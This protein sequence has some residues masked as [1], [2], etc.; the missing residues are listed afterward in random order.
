MQ[1]L[2]NSIR[3]KVALSIVFVSIGALVA[4]EAFT[5]AYNVILDEP[6]LAR[7][8]FTFQKPLIFGL[9][10]VFIL[11]V[12]LAL[13]RSLAPLYRYV[14]DPASADEALYARARRAALGVPKAIL[15]INLT[16]WIAGT[17]V[18]F[19]LNGWKAPGGTPLG[20]V[21]AFKITEG[22]LFSTLNSLIINRLLIEPKTLL[23]IERVRTGEHDYFAEY[24]E[25][26]TTLLAAATSVVHLAY[27]ARY[28]ILKAPGSRGPGNLPLSFAIVGG[29]V[30]LTATAIINL[31]QRDNSSQ[32]RTLRERLIGLAESGSVDLSAKATI[33]N[34]DDI[35]SVADAFNAYAESL[36]RMIG[37]IGS[38]TAVLERSCDDLAAGVKTVQ[39][40]LDG[41]KD[42]VRKIGRHVEEETAEIERSDGVI[43]SMGEAI[44]RQRD[45]LDAQAV[46]VTESSAGIEQMI[47]SLRSVAGNVAQI[48]STYDGLTKATEEGKRRVAETD[49]TIVKVAAMSGELLEANKVIAGVAAQTNLLAM[50]AAIEA[51]H[52]GEAGAGFSVVA[53]EIR[54]LAEKSQLQS[55]EIGRFL[56]EMKAS[57]DSA[58]TSAAGA[59]RGYDDVA[60]YIR[61]VIQSEAEI[62]SALLELS[63]G[64]QQI[65]EALGS[66]KDVTESVRGGAQDMTASSEEILAKM[67][68][69]SDL[70][71][72]TREEMQRISA[73]MEDM[74]RSFRAMVGQIGEN[75]GAVK[76]VGAEIQRFAV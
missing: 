46:N 66:M 49:T 36:K 32:A 14:D 40:E 48:E 47:S 7:L 55:K 60:A 38:S 57:I 26:G 67:G 75:S 72:R 73:D 4:G 69:L 1:S 29:A 76:G 44:S 10:S 74:A 50:N 30:G 54:S 12:T 25:I 39:A 62:R 65:L 23:N 56:K 6:I 43:A 3:L 61:T 71:L 5:H 9:A 70:A 24:R 31:S 37:G 63:S 18:F 17:I 34:F 35:G 13:E 64:S 2:K 68:A 58:V 59:S 22:A 51:A 28:F 45:A 15:T 11:F 33:V 19:A 53:D 21:L 20:W 16:F 52:A 27:V 8:F 42:S 41:I